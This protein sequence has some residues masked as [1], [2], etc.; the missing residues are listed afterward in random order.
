ML[1]HEKRARLAAICI[2][3]A[4]T[5]P[6]LFQ[7]VKDGVNLPVNSKLRRSRTVRSIFLVISAAALLAIKKSIGDNQGRLADWQGSDPC[8]PPSWTGISCNLTT[9]N[10]SVV[11]E[12]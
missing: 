3:T 5:E 8:G 4:G 9:S 11:R 1:R 12:M 10:V 7:S 6:I 2:F